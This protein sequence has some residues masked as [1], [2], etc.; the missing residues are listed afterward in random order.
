MVQRLRISTV[1]LWPLLLPGTAAAQRPDSDGGEVS[2]GLG[3]VVSPR[4]FDDA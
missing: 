1:A 3:A 2:L 4:P